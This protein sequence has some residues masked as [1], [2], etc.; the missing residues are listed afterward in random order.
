[1][2]CAQHPADTGLDPFAERGLDRSYQLVGV[3]CQRLVIAGH[4]AV[5]D[6]ARR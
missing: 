4:A 6:R 3:G 1:M 5:S 2:L